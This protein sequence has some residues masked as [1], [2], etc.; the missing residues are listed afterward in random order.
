MRLRGLLKSDPLLKMNTKDEKVVTNSTRFLLR[1]INLLKP[2]LQ[3]YGF[4]NAYIDD[5]DH[6]PHYENCVYL[7]F[8]P[9][10][11]EALEYFIQTQREQSNLVVEEYDHPGGYVVIIY[12]FPEKFA[13]DY[14]LF[15]QGK[16]S[17]LSEEYK[18][19]FP[20]EKT[21]M[22]SKRV[23]TKE[24]SFYDLVFNRKE[25][26]KNFWEERLGVILDVDSE[27]WSSPTISEETINLNDKSNKIPLLGWG[28]SS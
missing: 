4:I 11:P 13:D 5:V 10:D 1:G 15:L 27:Y 6:E 12:R 9:N 28:Q 16:Y 26:M 3:Q 7:L 22:T 23:P 2:E 18:N 21:G 14:Q 19:L 17:K 8:K 25:K 24:S 20:M